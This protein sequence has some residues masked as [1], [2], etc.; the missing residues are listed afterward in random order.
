MEGVG[1]LESSDRYNE[2]SEVRLRHVRLLLHS[3]RLVLGAAMLGLVAGLLFVGLVW[4][5]HDPYALNVAQRLAPV[6]TPGFV[7]G[8]DGAGRDVLSEVMVGAR[9]SLLVAAIASA[10]ALVL[11]VAA[12]GAAATYRGWVEEGV[13]RG[14]ELLYAFPTVIVALVISAKLGPGDTAAI[15]AI[16]AFFAPTTARIVRGVSLPVMSR[17]WVLAA[18]AYGR[19]REWIYI[20][21]VLPNIGATLIVQATLMFGTSVL[22]EASLSYIGLGAQP[23]TPSWGR[24]LHDAQSDIAIHPV[25][26]VWPGLAIIFTVLGANLLGD[27]LREYS[28]RAERVRS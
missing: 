20:R 6:G 1:A 16:V 5:P 14:V 15:A 11:G 10:I 26:A 13:M 27:G 12:G 9:N 18:R 28:G 8:T 2:D 17:D 25:L 24:M 19:S 7:L 3:P 21:Q 4:T 23:P 22:I